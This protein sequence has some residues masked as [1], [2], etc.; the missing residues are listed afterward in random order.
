V[1]ADSFARFST[2][3]LP[4]V[5]AP[6]SQLAVAHVV[7]FHAM[8]LHRVPVVPSHAKVGRRI[9]ASWHSQYG[10]VRMFA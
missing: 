7:T 4:S 9:P 5:P 2:A 1:T 8:E 6:Q 10:V 3:A